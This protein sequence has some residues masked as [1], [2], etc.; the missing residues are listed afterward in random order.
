MDNVQKTNDGI[1][2]PSSQTFRSYDN[3]TCS[4]IDLTNVF[5]LNVASVVFVRNDAV[6]LLGRS[7]LLAETLNETTLKES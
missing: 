6:V 7:V 2:M 4:Y 5:I 3:D 1:N